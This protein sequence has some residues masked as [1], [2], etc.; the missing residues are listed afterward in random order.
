MVDA[1]DMLT[2]RA[3]DFEVFADLSRVYHGRSCRLQLAG[4]TARP[5]VGLHTAEAGM[6]EVVNLNRA[7]KDRAKAE[8]RATATVNRAAHGQS[9][10]ERTRVAAERE[11]AAR[12]LDGSKL[13]D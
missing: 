11:R 1:A 7:R 13:E 6:G 10:A 9:K 3:D 8:A 4:K 12:L 5:R 2:V